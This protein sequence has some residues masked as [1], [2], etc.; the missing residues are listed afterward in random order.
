MVSADKNNVK[1][2]QRG[3]F[4]TNFKPL[5]F[6]ITWIFQVGFDVL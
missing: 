3:Q 6:L 4:N 5:S 2:N 1:H